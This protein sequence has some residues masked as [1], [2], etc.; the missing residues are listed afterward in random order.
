MDREK[1][2]SL[3]NRFDLIVLRTN[4]GYE[5]KVTRKSHPYGPY[6]ASGVSGTLKTAKKDARAALA[7]GLRRMRQTKDPGLRHL[8]P[9]YSLKSRYA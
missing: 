5:W 2:Y 4:V 8:R 3:T 1:Y 7:F 9:I 6:W